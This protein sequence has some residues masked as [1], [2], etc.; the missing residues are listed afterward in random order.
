MSLTN[1]F[2]IAKLT[3]PP[4]TNLNMFGKSGLGFLNLY[5]KRE[6]DYLNLYGKRAHLYTVYLARC[7]KELLQYLSE[8]LPIVGASPIKW[9]GCRSVCT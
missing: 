7:S 2:K 5:G 9:V 8:Q 4:F 1:S 3:L 6:P